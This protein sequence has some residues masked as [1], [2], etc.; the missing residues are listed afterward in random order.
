MIVIPP[1]LLAIPDDIVSTNVPPDAVTPDNPEDEL[2]YQ[3][4]APISNGLTASATN[5]VVE[6]HPTE[7]WNA[8]M[9]F[10]VAADQ[11]IA[12]IVNGPT[13]SVTQTL[14]Y[15]D[16]LTPA[17]PTQPDVYLETPDVDPATHP[18]ATLRVTLSNAV[19]RPVACELLAVGWRVA[20]GTTLYGTEAGITDY[21][22]KDR[23]TFGNV[24]LI[25]RGYSDTVRYRFAI[26]SDTIAAARQF[27][28][29]RRALPTGYLG[30]ESALATFVFGLYQDF[31]IPIENH[32]VSVAELTVDSVVRTGIVETDVALL[33]AVFVGTT[34]T[35]CIDDNLGTYRRLC[36]EDGDVTSA[37]RAA[38]VLNRALLQGETL[39]W[40]INWTTGTSS[41]SGS[42]AFLLTDCAQNVA[43]LDWPA[44][45]LSGQEPAIATIHVRW[46]LLD[47]ITVIQSNSVVLDVSACDEPCSESFWHSGWYNAASELFDVLDVSGMVGQE[48]I[49]AIATVYDDVYYRAENPDV[50]ANEDDWINEYGELYKHYWGF[51]DEENRKPNPYFDPAY[52]KAQNPDVVAAIPQYFYNSLQH[53][54]MFGYGEGRLPCSQDYLDTLTIPTIPIGKF[55]WVAQAVGGECDCLCEVSWETEFTGEFPPALEISGNIVSVYAGLGQGGS[56]LEQVSPGV[57]TLTP[58]VQCPP[59][60]EGGIPPAPITL[61]PLTLTLESDPNLLKEYRV[62]WHD[63]NTGL[64]ALQEEVGIVGEVPDH[65]SARVTGDLRGCTVDW[66]EAWDGSSTVPTLGP[67]G[68]LMNVS[69]PS[70]P[71]VLTLTATVDCGVETFELSPIYLTITE[72]GVSG[73]APPINNND[74]PIVSA[75]AYVN[76]ST[77]D[78]CPLSQ[79]PPQFLSVADTFYVYA[80]LTLQSGAQR[81]ATANDNLSLTISGDGLDRLDGGSVAGRSVC[82]ETI[83]AIAHSACNLW[84]GR[85][86]GDVYYE[87]IGP[88]YSYYSLAHVVLR[89]PQNI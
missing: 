52:Y 55:F 43:I 76:N 80:Y 33:S 87:L 89:N 27:L 63:I 5:I 69:N 56:I 57:L 9:L 15:A 50:V 54:Q 85:Q 20:V 14:R 88:D 48:D 32:N 75:Q 13:W 71:G 73:Y 68:G 78:A 49:R 21:S 4:F 26:A 30:A 86:W 10:N 34:G 70:G 17:L 7:R 84:S 74:D 18:N 41:A 72:E 59:Q 28:A 37:A 25:E 61:D 53:Y 83:D 19:P 11:L 79:S 24:T 62:G 58:T 35:A 36:L 81:W 6:I 40:V 3:M 47:G 42:E 23:D 82:G 45:T 8:V 12:S 2:R 60:T 51:G 29:S 67:Y 22:R 39:E 16:P 38:V 64:Y 1:V 46:T 44:A 65:W 31:A 77:N 66:A